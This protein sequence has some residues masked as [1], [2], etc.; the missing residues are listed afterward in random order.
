MRAF[1]AI[2]GLMIVA[3]VVAVMVAFLRP[4]SSTPADSDEPQKPPPPA[5]AAKMMDPKDAAKGAIRADLEIEGR[6][7]IV[8][9][10]YPAAAPK[11][12][13]HF[14]ELCNKHFYDGVLVH[15]VETDPK[16]KLFQAGDPTSKNV[17]PEQLRGKTSQQVSSEFHL[18][19]EGS[20]TT[21]P[22]EARLPNSAYSLG[23]ARSEAEDSGDSQFYVN[24]S[25]NNALDGK[26]CVFGRVVSGQDTAAG[27]Q[28]GDRIH[29]LTMEKQ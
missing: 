4:N 27:V 13:A 15:R 19:G 18:G 26:Y 28:I 24:L 20:G 9:D 10:L 8:L 17:K 23:L 29:K 1:L 11:T 21:V 5:P 25:D 14:V 7:K 6:G 12:V 22:L 16:F 2:A 3:V